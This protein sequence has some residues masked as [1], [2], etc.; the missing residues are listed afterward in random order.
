MKNLLIILSLFVAFASCS[1]KTLPP[2]QTIIKDSII[3]KEVIRYRTDT[4]FLPG[5]TLQIWQ[6]IPCPGAKMD[7]VII[8]GKTT[9]SAKILNGFIRID[10]RTDS[11]QH[12]IDSVISLKQREIIHSEISQVPYEVE[13]IVYKTPKWVW[14]LVAF[15]VVYFGFKFRNPILSFIKGFIK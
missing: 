2:V 9:L 7:T 8:K 1:R 10:C 4:T 13:T 12:I 3:E 11:L 15:V 5:D 14:W 6:A